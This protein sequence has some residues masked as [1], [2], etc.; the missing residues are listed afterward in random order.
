M[1]LYIN[2]V[3]IHVIKTISC[4]RDCVSEFL[5]ELIIIP[6]EMDRKKTWMFSH[7]CIVLDAILVLFLLLFFFLVYNRYCY[8]FCIWNVYLRSLKIHRVGAVRVYILDSIFFK[9]IAF[10]CKCIIFALLF[11]FR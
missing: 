4:V 5:P 11:S 6:N 2:F 3:N 10:E 8:C 1:Y 9:Y 7:C